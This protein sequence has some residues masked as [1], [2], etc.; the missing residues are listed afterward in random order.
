MT[1][2]LIARLRDFQNSTDDA[3]E[4]AAS[5]AADRIEALQSRLTALEGQE[6]VAY[7][8][9]GVND[10]TGAI[11]YTVHQGPTLKSGDKLFLASGAAP[12]QAEP[13]HKYEL[14]LPDG[15]TR[16]VKVWWAER[17]TN[18]GEIVHKLSISVDETPST[19]QAE[20]KEQT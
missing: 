6:P 11:R 9:V 20:P 15:D 3:V 7:F 8:D 12:Q 5:E 4:Q 13:V 16:K 1:D 10:V 18:N 19:V 17:K 14:E 2:T